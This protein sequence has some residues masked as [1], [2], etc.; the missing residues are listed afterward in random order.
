[1]LRQV[2][3]QRGA[4]TEGAACVRERETDLKWKSKCVPQNNTREAEGGRAGR[5]AQQ[6]AMIYPMIPGA[7][8]AHVA[9]ARGGAAD[10]RDLL[11]DRDLWPK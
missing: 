7:R 3:L 1:M 8:D 9:Q 10:A 5:R 6:L 11:R 4:A 2:H